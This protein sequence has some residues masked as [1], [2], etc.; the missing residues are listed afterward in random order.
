MPRSQRKMSQKQWE[1]SMMPMLAQVPD[2]QL[3]FSNGG[4]GRDIQLYLTGDDP[5][6]VE[7]TAHQV[8]EEMQRL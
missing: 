8:I 5:P 4:G 3:N 6:L 2:G 7:R 1:Q